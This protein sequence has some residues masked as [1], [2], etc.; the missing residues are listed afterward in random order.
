M[1]SNNGK[2][3]LEDLAI[4][5]NLEVMQKDVIAWQVVPQV[6]DHS[7]L[8]VVNR[9]TDRNHE[10]PSA[11]RL[12]RTLDQI[13]SLVFSIKSSVV[14]RTGFVNHFCDFFFGRFCQSGNRKTCH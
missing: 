9:L 11:R 2:V 1:R 8:R 5:V 10:Q 4:S 3:N 6:R 12:D 13:P 14:E 7:T